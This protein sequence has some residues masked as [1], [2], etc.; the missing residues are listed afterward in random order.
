MAGARYFVDNSDGVLWPLMGIERVIWVDGRMPPRV[1]RGV[2]ETECSAD[3]VVGMSPRF[4]VVRQVVGV[5][6]VRGRKTNLL[7][8]GGSVRLLMRRL[9]WQ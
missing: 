2:R 8:R 9:T 4:L 7:H 6:R 5:L 3:R 1:G